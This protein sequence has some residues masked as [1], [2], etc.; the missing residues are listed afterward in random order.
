MRWA[1]RS[2]RRQRAAQ[3]R[4]CGGRLRPADTL[5][6]QRHSTDAPAARTRH[7]CPCSGEGETR[8]QGPDADRLRRVGPGCVTMA[9]GVRSPPAGSRPRLPRS[10]TVSMDMLERRSCRSD[11]FRAITA[12]PDEDGARLPVGVRLVPTVGDRIGSASH[13]DRCDGR[14][15]RSEA[16]PRTLSE[17]GHVASSAAGSTA[18][19]RP[20]EAGR[21]SPAGQASAGAGV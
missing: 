17:G 3:L 2:A 21:I 16:A 15:P 5:R 8:N 7:G 13:L 6:R 19:R 4:R 18:G 14:A 20:R 11:V 12:P 10:G 1:L 9:D